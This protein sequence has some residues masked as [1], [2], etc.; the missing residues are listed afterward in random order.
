MR[1]TITQHYRDATPDRVIAAY[2]DPALY[3]TFQGLTKVAPPEVLRREQGDGV[4]SIVLQMRFVAAL[5]AAARR[6][7]DPAK[8]SWR[9][10]ER[11]DLTAG[12]ATVAFEP[13]NYAD[14]F[15][16]EGTYTFAPD[17][18]DGSGTVRTI[19]GDLHVR[20]LLVGGQVEAAFVS[21]L[22]E[23]FA[24]EQPLVQRW[25]DAPRP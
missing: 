22:R 19:S 25:L 17:P 4:V 5:N 18:D 15:G 14:R 11:Y 3:T 20:M 21:G 13:D 16:C 1:F 23:H 9:Q 2:T 7:I 8:L 24:E 10:S 12:T 6:V